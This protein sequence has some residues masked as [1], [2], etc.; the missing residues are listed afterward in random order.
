[1]SRP[2]IPPPP[3]PGKPAVPGHASPAG[4]RTPRPPAAL[5]L[6]GGLVAVEGVALVVLSI[7]YAAF[8]VRDRSAGVSAWFATVFGL[9]AGA[10]LVAVL[11]RG[12]AR[13]ARRAF[14]PAL[15]LELICL[16][17]AYN[18]AKEHRWLPAAVVAVLALGTLAPLLVG[19]ARTR[20]E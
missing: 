15:L 7:V 17:E 8:A 13:G 14:A 18:M 4:T 3:R 20:D 16:G 2:R 5:R 9:A 19:I 12:L 11:A 10:V 1:M 6:A